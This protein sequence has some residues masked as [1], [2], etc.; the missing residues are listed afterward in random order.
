[1]NGQPKS[2]IDACIVFGDF[3][4]THTLHLHYDTWEEAKAAAEAFIAK[5]PK[6]LKKDARPA[7]AV[8]SELHRPNRPFDSLM[9]ARISGFLRKQ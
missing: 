6:D 7:T 3:V 9:A 5:L 4:H 2:W 1:M 8:C